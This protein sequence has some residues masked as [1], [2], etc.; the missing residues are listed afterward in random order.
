MNEVVQN[1]AQDEV[2]AFLPQSSPLVSEAVADGRRDVEL[3][4]KLDG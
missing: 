3:V 4:G 1:A 2:V